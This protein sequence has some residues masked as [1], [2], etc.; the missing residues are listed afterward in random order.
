MAAIA[1][2]PNN[3]PSTPAGDYTASP[4]TAPNGTQ[5]LYDAT[6]TR[7]TAY[8]AG[9]GSGTVTA[10]SVTTANGISGSVAT[11]TTT[12]AIT[13]TLGAITPTS[14]NGLTITTSTGTLTIANGKTLTASN[15]LTLTGTDGS[16]LAIGTGGTLGTAA[17]VNT[18][19]GNTNAIL[20]NDS[21]LTN[22]RLPV[23]HAT[24]HAIGGSDP[25]D[26]AYI[27]LG[28]RGDPNEIQTLLVG[29]ISDPAGGS[30]I[31]FPYPRGSDGFSSRGVVAEEFPSYLL[32]N[33]QSEISTFQVSR[34]ALESQPACSE[35]E[36]TKYRK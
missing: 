25:L 16:T 27:S 9:S 12:P 30:S 10:V 33:P 32:D 26:P 2:P 5:W 1:Y 31:F 4:W 34:T 21:R 11:A 24:S 29:G 18:G 6:K 28:Y 36:P 14:V 23:P 7:W 22:A 19:T 17:Y 35:L 15:T 3:T 13:I 8:D 20:G